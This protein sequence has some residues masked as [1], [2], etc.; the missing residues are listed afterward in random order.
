[1]APYS[2]LRVLYGIALRRLSRSSSGESRRWLPTRRSRSSRGCA[3]TFCA[4][5][6]QPQPNVIATSE[7]QL[8]VRELARWDG[9]SGSTRSYI[10]SHGEAMTLRAIVRR[11]S[12]LV[13]ELN[14][15]LY[16]QLADANADALA[17]ANELVAE[18][19]AILGGLDMDEARRVTEEWTRRRTDP[20][21]GDPVDAQSLMG[22]QPAS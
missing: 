20:N 22:R 6:L 19:N 10:E 7:I 4:T 8:S 15:W 17:E 3:T 11:H 2:D 9:W 5:H 13:I 18:R 21:P 16:G 1:M 12:E 14:L